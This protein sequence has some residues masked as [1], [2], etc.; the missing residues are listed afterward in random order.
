LRQLVTRILFT[1]ARLLA[2]DPS[3]VAEAV[4]TLH[5]YFAKNEQAATDDLR[6]LLGGDT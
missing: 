1:R 3:R 4:A 6:A 2:S 5:D